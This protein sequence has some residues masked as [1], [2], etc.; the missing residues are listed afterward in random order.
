ME[1]ETRLKLEHESHTDVAYVDICEPAPGAKIDV[2]E[3]G[4]EMG[5][6]LGQVMLRLDREHRQLLGL[7]IHEFSSFK[8]QLMWYYTVVSI[9]RGLQLLVASLRAGMGSTRETVPACL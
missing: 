8:H 3:V 9:Q 1:T 7:T 6:P 2:V 4:S 5:F